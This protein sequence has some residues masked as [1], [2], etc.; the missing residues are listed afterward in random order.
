[1]KKI[2]PADA[3]GVA[4][5]AV[6]VEPGTGNVLSIAQNTYYNPAQGPGQTEVS[7]GVDEVYGGSTGFQ[8]GSTAKVFTLA[9]WLSKGKGLYTNVNGDLK[10]RQMNDFTACG[11]RLGG[12]NYTFGNS[13]GGGQPSID[14]LSATVHSVNT[15][16]VDIESRLDMC[17][18]AKVSTKVGVHLASKGD[19]SCFQK[20]ASLT[21]VPTQCP[22][23]TLGAF[24]VSPMTM[25]NA[26][27]TFA[28]DGTYCQPTP[29]LGIKDRAGKA[30][31]VGK[32][33]CDTGAVEPAVAHGVTFAL[34][35][36]ITSGTGTRAAG[37]RWPAAGKTGTTD[38]SVRT[39]FVGYTAQ[40]STA[41]VV[42]D[43]KIYDHGAYGGPGPRSLNNRRI[44][45]VGYG[46]VFG[47]T[48]AAP[49]WRTI[50]AA[51]MD[52]LERKDWPN[53]T[54]KMLE[55]SGIR[56]A[57]VTGRS[58]GEATAILESQGFRVRVGSPVK[59]S[60]GN[61][62]VAKTSPPPGGR[63]EKGSTVTIYPGDGSQQPQ[64]FPVDPGQPGNGGGNGGGNNGGGNGNGGG[65]GPRF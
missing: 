31:T 48:I 38:S 7:Y 26:Y 35:R 16:F 61:D 36:V 25:A 23:L 52:G 55:G 18:I 19:S 39:W 22:S 47:A 29:V 41:V 37:L 43:P 59:S 24:N 46:H 50:T 56:V 42:A 44:G 14:V 12:P 8:I 51:A 1:M 34:K 49:L 2:P 32:T 60:V 63:L 5:S 54:G 45:G 21:S 65:G 40:R 4:A 13:E 9:T 27:A 6:T 57:D 33:T 64:P 15:A 30:L 3:S 62:R 58:L 28:A 20:G 17:D 11:D 10:S 53:P